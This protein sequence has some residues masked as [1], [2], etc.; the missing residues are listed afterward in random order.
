[1]HFIRGIFC[2]AVRAYK[3]IF[4]E[5]PTDQD[6]HEELLIGMHQ[7]GPEYLALYCGRIHPNVFLVQ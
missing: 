2:A 6:A 5:I 1:M 3:C 4:D 7:N